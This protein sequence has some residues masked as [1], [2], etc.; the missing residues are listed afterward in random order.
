MLFRLLIVLIGKLLQSFNILRLGNIRLW[1][2]LRSLFLVLFIS[3]VLGLTTSLLLRFLEFLQ[4]SQAS[5]SLHSLVVNAV[6]AVGKRVLNGGHL[7]GGV[8][9][10]GVPGSFQ[11]TL[12]SLVL[13]L[14]LLKALRIYL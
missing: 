12:K 5:F 1:D 9:G 8:V 13:Q 6:L 11:E 2:N 3:V 7:L 14:G 10:N 4:E